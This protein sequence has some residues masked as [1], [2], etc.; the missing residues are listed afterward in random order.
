MCKTNRWHKL[1][2]C[3]H[4]FWPIGQSPEKLSMLLLSAAQFSGKTAPPGIEAPSH[5]PLSQGKTLILGCVS[6]ACWVS[7]GVM[8]YLTEKDME[9]LSQ[10][11]STAAARPQT[12]TSPPNAI[13]PSPPLLYLSAVRIKRENDWWRDEVNMAKTSS[14]R[15]HAHSADK[16]EP[17]PTVRCLVTRREIQ[18]Y[19][20][21]ATL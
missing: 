1:P 3:L 15:K 17:S 14:D 4:V 6:P 11:E 21:A 19:K 8:R 20:D 18:T 16:V 9:L 10:G 5:K 2:L 7:A 13:L 12:D